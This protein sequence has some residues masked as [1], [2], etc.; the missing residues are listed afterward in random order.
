MYE[1]RLGGA[2]ATATPAPGGGRVKHGPDQL[3]GPMDEQLAKLESGLELQPM[4]GEQPPPNTTDGRL[5]PADGTKEEE[6]PGE[7]AQGQTSCP[8]ETAA[9]GSY[10]RRFLGNCHAPDNG[11]S[12]KTG[13]ATADNMEGES[14]ES[15]SANEDEEAAGESGSADSGQ[16]AD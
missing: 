2:S 5:E 7:S 16:F 13:S 4:D 9:P 6:V 14:G 15:G 12:G 3:L 8:S 11:E 1:G 10:I